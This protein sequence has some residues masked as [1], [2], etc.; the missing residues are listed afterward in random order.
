[1]RRSHFPIT[2]TFLLVL[3]IAGGASG[4]A[5]AHSDFLEE[6]NQEYGTGGTPLDDCITCHLSSNPDLNPD[7]NPYGNDFEDFGLDFDAIELKDSDHDGFSNIAEINDRTFPGHPDSVPGGD[8]GCFIATAGVYG[9]RYPKTI[10]IFLSSII[11][12]TLRLT[13]RCEHFRHRRT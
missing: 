7:L 13:S 3:A 5:Y 10:L 1:M 12:I 11:A 2:C 9:V 8:G 4:I 6:F